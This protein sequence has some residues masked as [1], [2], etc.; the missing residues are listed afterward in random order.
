[1]CILPEGL[2]THT[3]RSPYWH[4][5]K[6]FASFNRKGREQTLAMGGIFSTLLWYVLTVPCYSG[7]IIEICNGPDPILHKLRRAAL[8]YFE[9]FSL[10]CRLFPESSRKDLPYFHLF[11]F[12]GFKI[13]LVS[14]CCPHK[15]GDKVIKQ[16]CPQAI[17]SMSIWNSLPGKVLVLERRACHLSSANSK[18]Q[19]F[20]PASGSRKCPSAD[21]IQISLAGRLFGIKGSC[22]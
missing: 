12:P 10:L 6:C 4:N 13:L 7:S 21:H 15:F 9:I 8:K 11:V 5:I 17:A 20:L 18:L 3:S 19:V 22:I 16:A 1:M 14:W 2:G